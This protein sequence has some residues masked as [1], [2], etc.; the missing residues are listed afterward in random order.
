MMIMEFKNFMFLVKIN[1]NSTKKPHS[2]RQN[3]TQ[4]DI[5][6]GSLVAPIL[7]DQIWCSLMAQGKVYEKFCDKHFDGYVHRKYPPIIDDNPNLSGT[8]KTSFSHRK[9]KNLT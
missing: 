5:I 2:G 8:S 1:Y 6:V 9:S 7:V 3:D 4:A